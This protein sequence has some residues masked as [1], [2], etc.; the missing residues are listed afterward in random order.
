MPE[1]KFTPGPWK[2]IWDG[3]LPMICFHDSEFGRD[4]SVTSVGLQEG[5]A[6]AALMAIAPDLYEA[7]M[8]ALDWI[9]AIPNDMVSLLPAM[10]G[11]DRDA[12]DRLCA[13]ARGES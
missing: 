2:V 3:L 1:T 13:K 6:N 8:D 9:D 5:R 4:F 12:V 7:L 11:F 10:P